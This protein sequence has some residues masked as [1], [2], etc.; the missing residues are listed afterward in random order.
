MAIHAVIEEG[1]YGVTEWGCY[2]G[3]TITSLHVLVERDVN[4]IIV[5]KKDCETGQ[6]RVPSFSMYSFRSCFYIQVYYLG[7]LSTSGARDGSDAM[8]SWT[9]WTSLHELEEGGALGHASRVSS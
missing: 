4:Q 2:S 6:L 3:G 9:C 7:L 5:F 1:L 8:T